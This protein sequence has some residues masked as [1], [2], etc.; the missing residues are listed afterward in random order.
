[1]FAWCLY[2]VHKLLLS[3]VKVLISN[4]QAVL[5]NVYTSQWIYGI[6]YCIQLVAARLKEFRQHAMQCPIRKNKL[7]LDKIVPSIQMSW[8][9]RNINIKGNNI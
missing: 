9:Q 4:L 7:D 5:S 6:L 8:R 1:M 2:L 3:H